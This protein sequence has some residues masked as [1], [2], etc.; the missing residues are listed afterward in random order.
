MAP[1]VHLAFQ[2]SGPIWLCWCD[3]PRAPPCCE[4]VALTAPWG[5]HVSFIG[6]GSAH[7]CRYGAVLT[8]RL[9]GT[10]VLLSRATRAL[11]GLRVC[12][13]GC[14]GPIGSRSRPGSTV[15][16][17]RTVGGHLCCLMIAYCC[18][19]EERLCACCFL[20][21]CVCAASQPFCTSVHVLWRLSVG[22]KRSGTCL[23]L[24]GPCIPHTRLPV[25]VGG[26]VAR[27]QLARG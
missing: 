23:W 9:P 11:A 2:L 25:T 24:A 10:G 5:P 18:C 6:G 13:T 22:P 27:L 4:L 17:Q 20:S 21:K 3:Q 19:A 1:R 15:L 16:L 14:W 8:S 7:A 12:V 26:P